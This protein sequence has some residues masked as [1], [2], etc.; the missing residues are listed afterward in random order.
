[1]GQTGD[2]RKSTLLN[3]IAPD[4]ELGKRVGFQIVWGRV[5]R[6]ELSA[7]PFKWRKDR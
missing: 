7:L 3:K 5:T 1:M 4:L 2:G 6:P